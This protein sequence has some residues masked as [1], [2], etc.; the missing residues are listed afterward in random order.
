MSTSSVVSFCK[1]VNSITFSAAISVGE[2]IEMTPMVFAKGLADSGYWGDKF[3]GRIVMEEPH[4][5]KG[6]LRKACK[7][8]AIYGLEPIFDSGKTCIIKIRNLITFGT[9]NEN[10]LVEKNYDITIQVGICLFCTF[11]I[12]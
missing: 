10:T 5:G 12:K 2:E 7:V 8:K 1:T 9:K 3:F 4:A 6:F 11:F